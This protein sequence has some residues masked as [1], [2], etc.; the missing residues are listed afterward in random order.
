MSSYAYLVYC[1]NL[2]FLPRHDTDGPVI[3]GN[4]FSTYKKARKY[5]KKLVKEKDLTLEPK[6]KTENFEYC[7]VG[8]DEEYIVVWMHRLLLE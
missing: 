5:A 1:S 4:L 2:E 8:T 3:Y 7:L 6:P